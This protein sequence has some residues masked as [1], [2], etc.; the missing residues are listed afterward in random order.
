MAMDKELSI[1]V[2]EIADKLSVRNLKLGVAESCTGG[3]LSN[4]ITNFP[5]AS[6]FFKLSVVSYSEDVK[7]SVLGVRA[8]IFKKHGMV[9]EET[10]IAMME[11]VMKLGHTDIALSVTG[12]AG[13]ERIED[14]D[15]GLVFIAAAVR[16][17]VESHGFKLSGDREEIKRQASLEALRFLKR[18]LDIWL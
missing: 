15:V 2:K 4:A 17:R 11:G 12:V 1:V 14:K 10:A 3:F 6:Q 18:V 7:K 8:S 5:G 9:S 16:D 13:P